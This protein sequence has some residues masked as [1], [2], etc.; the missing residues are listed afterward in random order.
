MKRLAAR[1]TTAQIPATEAK[2]ELG[3]MARTVIVFRDT[4]LER[5]RLAKSRAET[6]REREQRAEVIATTISRFEA[7]VDQALAKVREAAQR[8]EV[9]SPPALWKNSLP[10]SGK[11]PAKPTARP[12]SPP[13]RSTKRAAP[14][15]PCRNSEMPPPASA[16]LSD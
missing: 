16:K 1:D 3:E 4:L 13:A 8:L 5:E 7:S 14:C 11:L 6:N 15:T 2:D 12:R 9:T 10:P